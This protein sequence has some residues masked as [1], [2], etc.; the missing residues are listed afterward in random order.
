MSNS[1]SSFV[2]RFSSLGLG[3]VVNKGSAIFICCSRSDAISHAR[4][5]RSELQVRL[6]KDCGIGGGE[7]T[8]RLV[9]QSHLFVVL[10]TKGLMNDPLCLFEVWKAQQLKVPPSIASIS[11]GTRPTVSTPTANP[12]ANPNTDPS[13]DTH[14]AQA[15]CS[16]L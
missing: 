2:R 16:R 7:E 14:R 12:N 15:C 13:P 1:R 11:R 8:F 3:T 9:E 5:L 4:V 10:L 6:G